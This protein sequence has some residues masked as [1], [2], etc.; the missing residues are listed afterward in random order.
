MAAHKSSSLIKYWTPRYWPVWFLFGCLRISLILPVRWQ[1]NISK[2]V[3]RLLGWLLPERR[4]I[5]ERNLA[6]CFPKLSTEERGALV[7]KHFEAIGAAFSEIAMGWF[8]SKQVVQN[9][10]R[11]EGQEHLVKALDK[12]KGV[13]L[14]CG[15]FT[16]L[17]IL[18][19][20]LKPLCPK[21]TAMYR[22]MR[23]KLA[24][25]IM[26]RGRL[27]SFDQLFSKY[28]VRQLVKSLNDNSAVMY[29]TDQC[30][31]GKNSA[32]VPFFGEPAMTSTATTRLLRLS[33]A[34]LLRVFYK[35]LEDDTGYIVQ[36]CPPLENFPTDDPV[37]DTRILMRELEN[38]IRTCPEQYAWIHKRFK[39]RPKT[40]T[41]IYNKANRS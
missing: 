3:G 24:D 4:H 33:G 28:S 9:I 31:T 5:A 7:K 14:F 36:I 11:I 10:V 16:P 27:R 26:R 15:H 17:E 2:R 21:L 30:Y 37:R 12:G 38:H 6:V 23:N 40:Y 1:I 34:T 25:E 41:N 22:P 13:L 32:L 39:G 18:Y 19:P 8:G 35:R 29:L 20:A